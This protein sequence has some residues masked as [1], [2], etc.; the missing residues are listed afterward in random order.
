MEEGRGETLKELEETYFSL[1]D[2]E[3]RENA[4]MDLSY[5]GFIKYILD[6][7]LKR[8]EV[9]IE[10]L[11]QEAVEKHLKG[12]IHIHKLPSSL[13]IPYCV[14][15]SYYRLL[16]TGLVT[17]GT[18][19]RPPKHFDTALSQLVSFFYS[20]SQEWT[21]A[22]AVNGFDLYTAPFVA[23]DKLGYK[24]IKQALQRMIFDLNYPGRLGFQSPFTNITVLLDTNKQILESDAIV[25][26]KSA[27]V[28]G[29]YIE[30]AILV[31]KALFELCVEGDGIG[32]PFTFPIPTIML[33][34]DFD[35]NGRKWGDF[36]DI[37]FKAIAL[38][39]SA[40][41]LNGYSVNVEALYSMCCRLV[42]DVSKITE[43]ELKP[44]SE[45][46]S[47]L[48]KGRHAY[49]IWA[50]PDAT[51]SIGVVTVNLPRL[52][53]ESRGEWDRFVDSLRDLLELARSILK[54][55]RSKYEKTLR[56]GLMP[57]TKTYL[58]TLSNHYSTI[59]LI[60]LP[61]AAANFMGEP[62][63]WEECEKRKVEEAVN[64]EKRIVEEV[65][66]IVEEYEE[67]DGILYNVEEI[68]GES[69]AY[70]LAMLD[71]AK[72]KEKVEK[73]EVFIPGD[74][75]T[76]FYS[77]SIVPY[78]APVPITTRALL[79]SEVQKEFSGGVMMHLFLYEAADYE[80]LKKLVYRLATST[81]LVYF[82]ITPTVSV[83]RKC[84]WRRVGVYDACPKCGFQVDVWSR[85]VGYYR[86]I[87]TWNIG[88]KA[89]F[90]SRYHYGSRGELRLGETH[91]F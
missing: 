19:S 85:I 24:R 48:R 65:R 41:F 31:A 11:P 22:Q 39:G 6:K 86:P 33:T 91:V 32:Q 51:G 37:L 81:K 55:L 77:N 52:A 5:G 53:I 9:L 2:W 62:K 75:S 1:K 59:G 28:L 23:R 83:C 79:E 13:W 3:T 74:G 43:L 63:L 15:W 30:E 78:Y 61:E 67:V 68:P 25:G 42:V 90:R 73:G 64:I 49:G 20:V 12:Y 29:D 69:T 54:I 88:K 84:G 18:T 40:Y 72:F 58:G 50:I 44:V 35:W 60:G 17:P 82:S 57:L 26:G 56:A 45:L 16:K 80:A 27:G 46:E 76:F 89:E 47:F 14:G 66:E 38:R 4:N 36:V 34:R 71:Y 10:Y 70:R 87:R 7:L 8:R 21:G